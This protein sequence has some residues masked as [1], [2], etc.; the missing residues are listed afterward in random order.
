MWEFWG[1]ESSCSALR[2]KA[3]AYF[4]S[5]GQNEFICREEKRKAV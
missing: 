4:S 3:E 5:R 1:I 2:L